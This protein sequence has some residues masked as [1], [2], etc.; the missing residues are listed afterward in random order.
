MKTLLAASLILCS[1]LAAAKNS[2]IAVPSDSRATYTAVEVR[3]AG[4]K[5]IIVTERAGPSGS[6][7]AIR[8]VDCVARTFR[9][10]GEG[11]TL[12]EAR[13]NKKSGPMAPLV[14]GSISYYVALEA[15]EK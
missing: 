8:E 1:H 14:H 11:D 7:F 4:A 6:S 12:A 5:R 2:T 3:K 15:C 9:Y 10:L 13:Q